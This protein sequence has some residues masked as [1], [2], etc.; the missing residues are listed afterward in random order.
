MKLNK[1]IYKYLL[2]LLLF[3]LPT[4]SGLYGQA[5]PGKDEN[6]PFLV[7]F[8]KAGRNIMG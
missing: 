1:S 3:G 4:T 8:G 6:I 7:T 2:L 5:V